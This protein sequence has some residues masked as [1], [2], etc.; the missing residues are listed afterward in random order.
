[1]TSALH[2]SPKRRSYDHRL[3]LLARSS[4]APALG[5]LQIPRS[6][7]AT[8]RT[9][10]APKV[11]SLD[12][13]PGAHARLAA[14]VARLEHWNRVLIAVA[15]LL[16]AFLRVSPFRLDDARLPE[17]GAKAALLGAIDQARGG[18]SLSQCLRVLGISESRYHSWRRAGRLCALED[19]SSCPRRSPSVLTAAE[20]ATM[21]SL[22][23]DPL[24]RHFSVAALCLHA[25]RVGALFASAST[26]YRTAR[27]RG[28]RRPR[29]R[30]H[31]DKP[32]CG[33]RATRPNEYW[34][35]DVT[36]IRLLDGSKAYLQAVIDNFSR[37]IVAW[38]L[39]ESLAPTNTGALLAAA[40]EQLPQLS[41]PPT[42]VADSGVENVNGA[43]DAA[44]L[45]RLIETI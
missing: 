34:H 14:R 17:G 16:L 3:R 7:L 6:T 21:K 1:L 33:I 25:Q 35:I 26:W 2:S 19:R 11:I 29:N 9:R 23:L 10:R 4:A 44:L 5:H 38:R 8:W 45:R 27:E 32:T 30:V 13:A 18:L 15:R 39:E 40:A 22:F 28:W 41:L 42:L 20:L 12:E 36:V 37:K 24:L 31:P 43:V